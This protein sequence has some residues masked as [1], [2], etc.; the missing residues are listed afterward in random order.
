MPKNT[1]KKKNRAFKT[2]M[3][4]SKEFS[5]VNKKQTTAAVVAPKRF[6]SRFDEGK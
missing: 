5:K 4:S 6:R 3:N 1:K 2:G